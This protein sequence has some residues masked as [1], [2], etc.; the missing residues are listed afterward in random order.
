RPAT[1]CS[2]LGSQMQW[3]W[4]SESIMNVAMAPCR[5][6]S[7]VASAGLQIDLACKKIIVGFAPDYFTSLTVFDRNNRRAQ[8]HVVVRTHH[9]PVRSCGWHHE[10]IPVIGV[11]W[12]IHRI[13]HD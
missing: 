3:S 4:S 8:Q 6:C 12:Q 11:F 7:P 13:D 1:Q 10:Q 5:Y 2:G 9:M